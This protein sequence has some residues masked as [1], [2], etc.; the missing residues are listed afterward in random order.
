MWTLLFLGSFAAC[1]Y[2]IT[3]TFTE[4][5]QY[6]TSSKID[7]IYETYMP[8]PVVS[9]CSTNFFQTKAST[10]FAMKFFS[11]QNG[12]NVTTLAELKSVY[13]ITGTPDLR[14][15]ADLLQ[16]KQFVTSPRVSDETRKTFGLNRSELVLTCGSPGQNSCLDVDFVWYFD[17]DYGTCF[18]LNR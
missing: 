14:F 12:K 1:V 3:R 15:Y 8:M 5:F 18:R 2:F 16:L 4:Y 17:V 11:N 10:D 7:T 9:I 13:N 6:E